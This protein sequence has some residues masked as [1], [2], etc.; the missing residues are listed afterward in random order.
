MLL[1]R[2]ECALMNN[3]IRAVVQ[4]R[5]E[6][7]RL[8]SLGGRKSGG[9]AREIGCGRGVGIQKHLGLESSTRRAMLSSSGSAGRRWAN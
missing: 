3:P 9:V 6:A 8:L 5:L 7:H 4:R 1:N 2:L